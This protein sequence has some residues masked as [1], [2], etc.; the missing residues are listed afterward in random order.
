MRVVD[1]SK[2]R[3]VPSSTK[4]DRTIVGFPSA[5][6][7]FQ[8]AS[9]TDLAAWEE[10]LGTLV[11][12]DRETRDSEGSWIILAEGE[13]EFKLQLPKDCKIRLR[14]LRGKRVAILHTDLPGAHSYLVR[15]VRDDE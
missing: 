4:R 7:D 6:K 8:Q 3:G 1:E 5:R 2:A 9:V 10:I 14:K 12:L 15:E 13:S 11:A